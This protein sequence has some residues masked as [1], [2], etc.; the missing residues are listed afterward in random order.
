MVKAAS[1]NLKDLFYNLRFERKFIYIGQDVDDIIKTVVLGNKFCFREIYHRRRVNSMYFDDNNRTFYTMN[2][3]GDGI[4]E[5]YRVRWYGDD[6]ALLSNPTVEIKKKFGEA[7]DK[8][9]YKIKD[10][11]LDLKD[12]S[13]DEI[14]NLIYTNIKEPKLSTKFGFIFPTLYN[15]YDRRYFLSDCGKFRITID[16]NMIFYNPNSCQ[17]QASERSLE[18]VILEL[19]YNTVDDNEGREVSQEFGTRLSKNSKYVRGYEM[20]NY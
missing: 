2:V 7:G 1:K 3:S 20:F 10:L 17:F 14:C 5:K 13:V 9:S 11:S 8:Y 15:S 12:Y 19:K 16:Y 6:F 18:D 4:R